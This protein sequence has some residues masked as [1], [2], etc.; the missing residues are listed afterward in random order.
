MIKRIELYGICPI[1]RANLISL[2]L[3]FNFTVDLGPLSGLIGLIS[4]D[5]Y[6]GTFRL[7]KIAEI[8]VNVGEFDKAIDQLELLLSI[9]S[10][11]TEHSLR[12]DM[13][14]ASRTSTIC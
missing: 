14:S 6:Y 10:Y 12:L 13:G 4:K 1:Q 11:I 7:K 2:G 9:S 5:A 8:Y 3:G